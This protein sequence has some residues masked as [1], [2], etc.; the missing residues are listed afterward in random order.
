[1][2]FNARAKVVIGDRDISG[3]RA[4]VSKIT[5]KEGFVTTLSC[6]ELTLL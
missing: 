6:F 3:A 1:M 4:V 5:E 2:W